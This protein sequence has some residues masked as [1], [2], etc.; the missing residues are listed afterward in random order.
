M[1]KIKFI[2]LFSNSTLVNKT[3]LN[4]T[5]WGLQ[6]LQEDE[7]TALLEVLSNPVRRAILELMVDLPITYSELSKY[8][9]L[10]AGSIYH[11]INTL[12]DL[13]E[14]QSNKS[15]KLTDKGKHAI[16]YLKILDG[17]IKEKKK[18]V[19][20]SD[21]VNSP[22]ENLTPF[23]QYFTHHPYR[24]LIE[25]SFLF[26]FAVFLGSEISIAV[27]G[28]FLI[29]LSNNDVTN[30]FLLSL[31]GWFL[32][33]GITEI[34]LYVIYNIRT[35]KHLELIAAIS[36]SL[37]GPTIALA[38]L[39][40]NINH[41]GIEKID[42]GIALLIL[43]IIQLWMILTI[44]AGIKETTALSFSQALVIAIS[45]NYIFLVLVMFLII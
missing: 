16:E 2:K 41:V 14:Q 9:D 6:K 34:S 23:I 43:G 12:G 27:V 3:I 18:Q 38:F 36:S 26:L 29:P 31:A 10:K 15:Y 1:K 25:V 39:Y 44:T 19:T 17:E 7:K 8:L 42:E 32:I 13:V 21:S 11:H 22:L 28:S 30:Y 40:I 45:T 37:I 4:W 33:I 20:Q 35:D 24:S 5:V